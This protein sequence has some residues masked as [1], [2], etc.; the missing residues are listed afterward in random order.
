LVTIAV[1]FATSGLSFAVLL[2]LLGAGEAGAFLG[3]TRAMQ[4]WYP[5]RERGF[6]QGF[7]HSASRF[8]AFIAP[9]IIVFLGAMDIRSP[10]LGAAA[11]APPPATPPRSRALR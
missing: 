9:T 3:A 1:G 10:T 5:R 11:P 8:G 7:T 2:F 6:A 4:M